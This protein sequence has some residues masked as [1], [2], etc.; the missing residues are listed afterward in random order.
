MKILSNP[1]RLLT[2]IFLVSTLIIFSCKKEISDAT[3]QDEE[4]ANVTATQSDAEAENVFDGVFN[5]ALGVNADVGFGG[6][7]I[8]GRTASSNYGTADLNGRIDNT[9]LLPACLNITIEHTSSTFFPVTY[10]LDYG[11]TGCQANDGHL[12]RGK[13]I[14]T[15]TGGRLLYPGSTAAVTFLEFWIDSIRVDNSTVLTIA[16]TGTVD[17]LQFTVDVQAKLTKTNG[18]YSEW[19]SHKV[20]TRIEGNTTNSPL[21][22]TFK[23]EGYASG[24]TKR[25]DL[26]V[27]WKAEIID[28]LIKKFT[29][30]WISKGKVRIARENLS[31]NSQ[32]YG[33][34]DYGFPT[35]ICDNRAQLTVN[36][37]PHEITLR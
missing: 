23:M 32:W 19:H 13:M 10:T 18:N 2:A 21:D 22:D 31:S 26:I 37:L 28:P 29:C 8:F 3:A 15:Y 27:A 20:I 25:N 34:L 17:K 24:K 30:R 33:T 9:S 1:A 11:N 7:G 36:N 35:G 16:N 14:I 12:R 4:E 5:D 6:T